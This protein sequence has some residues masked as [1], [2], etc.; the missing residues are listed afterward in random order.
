[1]TLR[2]ARR[3]RTQRE[4][5]LAILAVL[6]VCI[7]GLT[8]RND[9]AFA[10]G[11]P[12]AGAAD[13]AAI[14]A[15][16]TTPLRASFEGSFPTMIQG[17][18]P[19]VGSSPLVRAKNFLAEYGDLYGVG[20]RIDYRPIRVTEPTPTTSGPADDIGSVLLEQT[21]DGLPVFGGNVT[22]LLHGSDVIGSLGG[23]FPDDSVLAGG[24]PAI[25]SKEAERHA[26]DHLTEFDCQ[27]PDCRI[28]GATR[29]GFMRHEVQIPGPIPGYPPISIDVDGMAYEVSVGDPAHHRLYVD[30]SSGDVIDGHPLRAD[31]HLFTVYDAK[32]LNASGCWDSKWLAV[33]TELGQLATEV[34]DQADAV[35]ES[36][37]IYD[38]YRS[39]GRDSYD[40]NNA[41]ARY[42]I[43]HP[44]SNTAAWSCG[45]MQFNPETVVTDVVGHEYTHAVDNYTTKLPYANESGALNEALADIMGTMSELFNA[46]PG[47]PFDWYVGEELSFGAIRHLQS[48][49]TYGHPDKM[50][51]FVVLPNTRNGDWGGVHTNSGIMNKA[52]Y[53]MANDGGASGEVFNGVRV[54]QISQW[55]IKLP[56]LIMETMNIY[57]WTS[58]KFGLGPFNKFAR[59]AMLVADMWA[60]T[61]KRGFDVED[62]CAVRNAFAATEIIPTAEADEDCDGTLDPSDPDDD[63]DDVPDVSDNC[64]H[65]WNPGQA[66]FDGDGEGDACDQNMDGDI[67]EN[68]LDNCPTVPNDSQ[69]DSDGDG[70][71]DACQDSDADSVVDANDNCPGADNFDQG[72]L[73]GD[74]LGDACDDDADDDGIANDDDNCVNVPNADQIDTDRGGIGDACDPLP[75][76]AF[77]DRNPDMGRSRLKTKLPVK[78][79]IKIELDSCGGRCGDAFFEP[80]ALISVKL[81]GAPKGSTAKILDTGGTT[82]TEAKKTKKGAL[83]ASFDA[84]G[85]GEHLLEVTTGGTT[86]ADKAYE[87]IVVMK[88]T[89]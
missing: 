68:S 56:R 13:F 70:I 21:V 61:G 20:S 69:A 36:R 52:A 55:E 77:N 75:N 12:E 82:L 41:R 72:D 83:V 89:D 71:G 62:A 65:H 63:R 22:I 26:I 59:S 23:G 73:D 1:M 39:L 10:A 46:D 81:K 47:D 66:D 9:P 19:T 18:I 15:A 40:G 28:V 51:N 85:S 44:T 33:A 35:R 53:L 8:V 50:S 25:S 57:R 43:N 27:A 88:L 34:N 84:G 86:K 67:L 30:A 7:M 64:P 79:P 48:P 3:R 11:I 2:Q 31:A 76:H 32:G 38:F 80:G 17:R 87:L 5:I 78:T 54:N 16:S 29:L 60:V 45:S 14:S 42:W 37:E 49:P 58:D 74:G 4:R 6:T 24:R